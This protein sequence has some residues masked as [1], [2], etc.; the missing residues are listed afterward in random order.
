MSLVQNVPFFSIMLS[1]FSGI[2]SSVLPVKWAK[3]LNTAMITIVAKLPATTF[4]A[5]VAIIGAPLLS[6]AISKSLD[7]A[8]LT[9]E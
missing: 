3:R 2:V 8:H 6:I 9:L 5:V 7:A 4:N 1:M